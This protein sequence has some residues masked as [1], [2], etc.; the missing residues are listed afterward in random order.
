MYKHNG[1]SPDVY[2]DPR[3]GPL[4]ST[5]MLDSKLLMRASMGRSHDTLDY[6]CHTF[7]TLLICIYCLHFGK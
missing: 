6:T 5:V 2:T 1:S 4:Q 7:S 3:L